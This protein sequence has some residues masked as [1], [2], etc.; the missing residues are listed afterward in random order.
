MQPASLSVASGAGGGAKETY[1]DTSIHATYFVGGGGAA[2]IPTCGATATPCAT[3]AYAI[4]VTAGRIPATAPGDLFLV[5]TGTYSAALDIS[6]ALPAGTKAKPII[7]RKDAGATPTI[8]STVTLRKDYWVLDGLTFTNSSAQSLKYNAANLLV[9]NCTFTGN[10]SSLDSDQAVINIGGNTQNSNYFVNNTVTSSCANPC[11]LVEH[12]GGADLVIRGNDLS[13]GADRGI[14]GTGNQAGQGN[15]MVADNFIHNITGANGVGFSSYYGTGEIYGARNR[16]Y[17][18]Q[19]AVD[20]RWSR[21]GFATLRNNTFGKTLG[22]NQICY[23]P[24]DSDGQSV[25]ENDLCI[26]NGYAFSP[27]GIGSWQNGHHVQWRN[28]NYYPNATTPTDEPVPSGGDCNYPVPSDCIDLINV[29]NSNPNLNTANDQP[30]SSSAAL[31]DK[32]TA[33]T[34]VPNGGGSV[35]DIGRYE[36]GATPV[37]NTP[38]GNYDY[39]ARWMGVSATPRISWTFTDADNLYQAAGQT[40]SAY[41]AQIDTVDTFDS[42]GEWKPLCSSGKVLT[43]NAFWDVPTS[44]GLVSGTKYYFRVRTWDNINTAATAVSMWSDYVNAFTVAGSGNNPANVNNLR[45]TD[46][47]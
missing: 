34:A 24:D 27:T 6:G 16:I 4:G 23:V 5:R 35:A 9:K 28:S 1:G 37:P 38:N 7:I 42:Q 45:R 25:V 26:D 29:T 40:Q 10:G 21:G 2:D 43:A 17:D 18:I 31:I 32:A 44:C 20:F 36:F 12:H 41:E 39:Q 22:M 8:S 46:S 3:V 13:G 30:T 47:H 19:G 15:I 11:A 33:T 14:N